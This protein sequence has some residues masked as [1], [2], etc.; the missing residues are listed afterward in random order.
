[1]YVVTG[2]VRTTNTFI[3]Q[4]PYAPHG[5][6]KNMKEKDIIKE[7]A[8][9]YPPENGWSNYYHGIMDAINY[10]GKHPHNL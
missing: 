6:E 5:M 4:L 9:E 10:G 7:I 1:M 2:E 8:R 3:V